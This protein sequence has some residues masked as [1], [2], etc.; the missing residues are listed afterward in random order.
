MKKLLFAAALMVAGGTLGLSDVSYAHGGQYRGPGDT[1]PPGGGGGGGGGAGPASGPAGP[2]TP[3]PSGPSSPGPAAPGAAPGVKSG[4]PTTAG[5]MAAGPDLTLWSFWWEFNKE[6][7][8]NLRDKIHS[9]AVTTGSE[10]FFLGQ[11]QQ[12]EGKDSLRPS[13]AQIRGS[14]VPALMKALE[15]ETNNDIVTGC[16]I[17]LA[18]IGDTKSESG[19]SEFEQVIA[20]FLSNSVQEISETSAV[21]LGILANEASIPTLAALLK[22]TE[23]GRKLVGS[24][25]VN[26]RTRAFAAYGLALIGARAK[27]E[28]RQQIV[29]HLREVIESDDTSARDLTV[30]CL[31]AMGVVPLDTFETPVVE[32]EEASKAPEQSRSAQLDYLLAY[33]RDEDNNFLYRAHAPTALARLCQGLPDELYA[34]YKQEIADELLK[35][36]SKRGSRAQNEIKQSAVLALGLLGDADDDDVDKKIRKALAD[37]PSELSDQ[38]ARNFSLVAMAKVGARKGNGNYEEGVDEAA[39]YLLDQL[40][41][42]KSTIQPWAGISVGV[43]GNAMAEANVDNTAKTIALNEALRSSLDDEKN[44]QRVGAYA[45]G[46]GIARDVE[47]TSILLEKLDRLSDDEAR[48]YVAVALG[49]MEARDSIEPI[50]TIV[51]ESKYRP[52]LLK[53]AAIALGLMGDKDLVPDLIEMLR[54]SKGLATQA[55]ISSALGFIGDQR[56]ID[57]LVEMLQN[58]D[59]TD[60]ARGFAAVALGIVADKEPLPWNTKLAVDLNYRASTQTLTDQNGTGILNIL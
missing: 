34:K 37:V 31:V 7:Y 40:A 24:T 29:R 53:Q 22:D 27:E 25:Q 60:R 41:K 52:E 20:K 28:P 32:G 23:Q 42:G 57:P 14:V 54:E 36:C 13:E 48:G 12:E 46:C 21:A 1:V 8:L 44:N 43:L 2:S 51:K 6:P 56:S 17:A 39:D 33:L 10:G 4:G 19:E 49:L 3:G 9:G 30:A 16:L 18:K 59:I 38:Q 45:I 35:H 11:G 47:S 50:Q 15:T 58:Q 5:G 55:A 26:Y